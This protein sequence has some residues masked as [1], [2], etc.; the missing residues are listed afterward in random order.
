MKYTK[1][2]VMV[3]VTALTAIAAVMSGG[4]TPTE[5]VTVAIATVGALSVFAAPNVPGAAYTKS[6]LAVF[7]AILAFLVTAILGGISSAEYLQIAILAAGAVGVYAF[8]NEVATP[9]A[10]R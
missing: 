4:I 1:F 6:I 8:P 3:I 5:W 10:V 2:I 7:T 9:V